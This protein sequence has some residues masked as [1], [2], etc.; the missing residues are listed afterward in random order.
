ML[1]QT[2]DVLAQVKGMVTEQQV[3]T[4]SGK[5]LSLTVDSLC[6]HGDHPEALDIAK[7]IRQ[8]LDIHNTERAI[9]IDHQ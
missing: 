1:Y 5:F 6:L 7:G 9:G 3:I 8:L 4:A 2:S